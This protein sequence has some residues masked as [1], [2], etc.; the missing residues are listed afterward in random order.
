MPQSYV[1]FTNI[2]LF[3]LIFTF[4]KFKGIC[5]IALFGIKV[6]I[7]IGQLKFQYHGTKPKDKRILLHD[8]LLYT[9]SAK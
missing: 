6:G 1:F 2:N 5:S 8:T 3:T 7:G 9:M 4:K